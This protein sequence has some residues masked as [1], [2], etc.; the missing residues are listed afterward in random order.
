[1][2][3]D[4]FPQVDAI[5]FLVDAHD[6]ERF[7]ESKKELDQLL[8]CE[9]LHDVPFLILGNKIDLGR[10][11]SEDELRVEL[12]LH[13]L[14]TGKGKA[15]CIQLARRIADRRDSAPLPALAPGCAERDSADGAL[16][17]QCGEARGLRRWL[18]M[19]EQL[20]QLREG[21]KLVGQAPT[22]SRVPRGP[23]RV[24]LCQ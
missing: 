10:A 4:Y 15:R 23:T 5:V 17:V 9:E 16:H 19:A 7:C 12:G 2:W 1:V 22:H 21:T 3:K 24:A 13:H 8:S 20:H 11:A 14:T 18:Q 6:R